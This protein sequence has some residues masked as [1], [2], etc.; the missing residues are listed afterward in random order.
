[1]SEQLGELRLLLH[2]AL[3]TVNELQAAQAPVPHLPHFDKILAAAPTHAAGPLYRN[4]PGRKRTVTAALLQRGWTRAKTR[5]GIV[6]HAPQPPRP[7]V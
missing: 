6:W 5:T 1:M 4:W 3:D 7:H 2:R